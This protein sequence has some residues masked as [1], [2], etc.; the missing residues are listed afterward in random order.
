MSPPASP[1]AIPSTPPGFLTPNSYLLTSNCQLLPS[2]MCIMPYPRGARRAKLFQKC[3]LNS[4]NISDPCGPATC[5]HPPGILARPGPDPATCPPALT[6][7][8]HSGLNPESRFFTAE[9]AEGR[10]GSNNYRPTT[11]D[12]LSSAD[13]HRWTPIVGWV[14]NPRVQIL[15]ATEVT[16]H[17]E[18]LPADERRFTQVSN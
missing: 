9:D 1:S 13:S 17:T 8:C 15:F 11:N 4:E 14:L 7:R 3:L 2:D 10:R 12:S 6:A 5:S 16:E 18:N